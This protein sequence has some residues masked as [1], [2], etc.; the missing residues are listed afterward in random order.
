MG[1]AEAAF[2][3]EESAAG[4]LRRFALLRPETSGVF[5]T[6]DGEEMPF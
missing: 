3:A 6:W 4:L 1:G 2:T 5:E